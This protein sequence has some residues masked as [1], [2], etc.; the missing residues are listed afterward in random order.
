MFLFHVNPRSPT[1]ACLATC[2]TATTASTRLPWWTSTTCSSSSIT[3]SSTRTSSSSL[4]ARSRPLPSR[5][6][7][8]LP[9]RCRRVC[10]P[11]CPPPG[12]ST[13]R[14]PWGSNSSSSRAVRSRRWGLRHRRRLIHRRWAF[15]G[16]C[17]MQFKLNVPD[18]R[19]YR[20]GT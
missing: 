14:R 10:L 3:N 2:P 17:N 16:V 19:V 1:T 13:V 8:R 9:R 12:H 20:I 6:L 5:L 11:G 7:L 18:W 15:N 4:W